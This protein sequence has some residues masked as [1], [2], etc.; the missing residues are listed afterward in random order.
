MYDGPYR[1][2]LR[3]RGHGYRALD[4][5]VDRLYQRKPFASDADR[6]AMLFKRYQALTEG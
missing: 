6:V 1:K 5:A 2:S 4:P 3:Y